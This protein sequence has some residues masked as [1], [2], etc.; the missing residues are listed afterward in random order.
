MSSGVEK[1]FKSGKNGNIK[2]RKNCREKTSNS[3]TPF[4][5]N[6]RFSLDTIYD[7]WD[8]GRYII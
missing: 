8:F 3:V 5:S 1:I 7:L 2:C 4:R 6:N